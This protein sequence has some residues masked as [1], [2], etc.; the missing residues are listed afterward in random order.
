MSKIK[1]I[2]I[3]GFRG[4]LHPLELD[5]CRNGIPRPGIVYGGNGTGKSSLTDAW[6]WF[7]TGKIQHL[8]RE[9]AKDAA[10]P[11]LLADDNSTFVEVTF[12]D[13]SLDTLRSTFESQRITQPSYVGNFQGLQQIMRHPCHL[14]FSDLSRFVYF[15][16]AERFDALA[17]LMGFEGQVEYL[18]SLRRVE[19]RLESEIEARKSSLREHINRLSSAIGEATVNQAILATSLSD[20]LNDVGFECDASID[21]VGKQHKVL[22]EAIGRDPVASQL[23]GLRSVKD[24]LEKGK[25]LPS[26]LDDIEAYS[27]ALRPFKDRAQDVSNIL[28]LDLFRVGQDVLENLNRIDYCPLCERPYDGNLLQH[29]QD[30]A[31]S[32]GELKQELDRLS[33]MRNNVISN[34]RFLPKLQRLVTDITQGRPW[35][36]S[37]LDPLILPNSGEAFDTCVAALIEAIGG[38]LS[39]IDSARI[40]DIRQEKDSLRVIATRWQEQIAACLEAIMKSIEQ[41]E[42]DTLRTRMVAA[43]T[44]IETALSTWNSIKKSELHLATLTSTGEELSEIIKAYVSASNRDI[45]SRFERISH[46]VD[47]YFGILEAQ[48]RGIDSALLKLSDDQDRSVILEVGFHGQTISPAYKYLSE[49]QLNS[50]GLAVFLAS[51]REFNPSFQVLILDDVINSFDAYKRPKVITLIQDEFKDFQVIIL[52]HDLIW[53]DSLYR[54][55]PQWV[56]KEF[57]DFSHK[58]GPLIRDGATSVE[59]VKQRIK[60]DRAEEAGMILGVYLEL[61]L[62]EICEAF[63]TMIRYRRKNDYTIEPLLDGLRKRTTSKLKDDHSLVKFLNELWEDSIFRNF[64]AHWKNPPTPYTCQELSA[65]VQNWDRLEAMVYCQETQCGHV[66][67]MNDLDFFICPCGA[68]KLM[69]I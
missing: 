25:F 42:A 49:S 16:K 41:I 60:E 3:S 29:I 45:R 40:T 11:H 39:S 62:Q 18:K 12:D 59:R 15:T 43:N 6:E 51:V 4:V 68:T 8:A 13:P 23:F 2:V 7:T 63:E 69:R 34:L 46:H 57:Y 36:E 66:L 26:I 10:Y 56:R 52:T 22:Q 50:F 21:E 54:K 53:R 1:K 61:C 32:L 44:L 9:G 17:S 67:R 33:K 58:L 55:F 24:D 37:K 48:T 28:L 19:G 20:R 14:R 38:E 64:C 27:N 35:S 47:R 31:S 65:I 30:H 5:F